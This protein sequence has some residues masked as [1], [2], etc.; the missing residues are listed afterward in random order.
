[1]NNQ[2]A[3]QI[4]FYSITAITVLYEL[5]CVINCSAEIPIK[6]TELDRFLSLN[7][8]KYV[9]V[10]W[11]PKDKTYVVKHVNMFR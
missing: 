10:L 8:S 1:M 2:L 4:T 11:K 7:L 3:I 6:I 9:I 5:N